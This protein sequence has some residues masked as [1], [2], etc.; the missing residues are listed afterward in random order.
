MTETQKNKLN[1][2]N[3]NS[4]IDNGQIVV[5]IVEEAIE[6]DRKIV[7]SGRVR[8]RKTT[9]EH[10]AVIDEPILREEVSVERVQVNKFVKTTPQPRKEGE[11]LIVPV[12]REEL[13]VEKKLVLVEELHINKKIVEEHDPQKVTL[14]K[15]KVNVENIPL[16]E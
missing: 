1:D 7:E 6:V 11:T 16:E 5:P 9:E 8:I 2:E 3:N 12:M 15:D 10:E 4:S 13:V 14:L